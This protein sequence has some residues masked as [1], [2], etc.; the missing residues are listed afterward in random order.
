MSN[1]PSQIHSEISEQNP[2]PNPTTPSSITTPTESSREPS[3]PPKAPK[4]LTRLEK[5]D[6]IEKSKEVVGEKLSEG[7][8][9]ETQAEADGVDKSVKE[10]EVE[11]IIDDVSKETTEE[12]VRE[13]R[14]EDLRESINVGVEALEAPGQQ[15]GPSVVGEGE[16]ADVEEPSVEV[17]VVQ[18]IDQVQEPGS[19]N[20]DPEN[21]E[22]FD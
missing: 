3:S 8:E 17:V 1:S 18:E 2:T 12:T 15:T 20:A 21:S 9:F 16:L 6:V 13:H 7:L 5:V 11:K 19:L 14:E 10:K 4:V 22:S